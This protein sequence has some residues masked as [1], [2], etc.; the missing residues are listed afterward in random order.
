MCSKDRERKKEEQTRGKRQKTMLQKTERQQHEQQKRHERERERKESEE[1]RREGREERTLLSKEGKEGRKGKGRW[2]N[3][4]QDISNTKVSLISFK[5]TSF[6]S[7]LHPFI[8]SRAVL[9]PL[10]TDH[11]I[12]MVVI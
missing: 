7:H 9:T 3:V 12:L 8:H 10:T 11:L 5:L 6:H 4:L 2:M 1:G